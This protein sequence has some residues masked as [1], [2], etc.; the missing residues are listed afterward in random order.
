MAGK[1]ISLL[2]VGKCGQEIFFLIFGISLFIFTGKFN[3]MVKPNN[4]NISN[5]RT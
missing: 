1:G 5:N 3:H 2:A 4:Q